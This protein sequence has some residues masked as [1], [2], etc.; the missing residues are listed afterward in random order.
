MTLLFSLI[1]RLITQSHLPINWRFLIFL[2]AENWQRRRSSTHFPNGNLV[3]SFRLGFTFPTCDSFSVE[4]LQRCLFL[5]VLL[6]GSVYSTNNGKVFIP[7]E[8]Q[9]HI[10]HC[11]VCLITFIFKAM[12]NV[13]FIQP[14][15][16]A[17]TELTCHRRNVLNALLG[18]AGTN[19]SV[20][21]TLSTCSHL[22][23]KFR[24][25]NAH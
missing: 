18:N 21:C 4:R 25:F 23:L 3:Q 17:V 15:S 11:L 24:L 8:Q 1:S 14:Q 7:F 22:L 16:E 2:V 10:F 6:Y 13:N 20:A 19:H 12:K 9:N 5:V